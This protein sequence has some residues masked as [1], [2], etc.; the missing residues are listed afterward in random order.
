MSPVASATLYH[1]RHTRATG[2]PCQTRCNR[3]A[4]K[5]AERLLAPRFTA[6]GRSSVSDHSRSRARSSW[7]IFR[8][9]VRCCLLK[10]GTPSRTPSADW[11]IF[12]ALRRHSARFPSPR[13]RHS[14]SS[15][16]R[17]APMAPVV[18]DDERCGA[19]PRRGHGGGRTAAR[20][21]DP[22]PNVVR[23]AMRADQHIAVQQPAY[24]LLEYAAV[25]PGALRPVRS[26]HV[27]RHRRRPVLAHECIRPR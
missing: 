23:P 24:E 18:A 7:A 5:R 21:A 19:N 13:A 15:S 4:E 14:G 25:F 20:R 2:R 3:V 8:G 12:R 16:R 1:L 22:L 9:R 6:A 17:H 27:S 11:G 10:C 26:P